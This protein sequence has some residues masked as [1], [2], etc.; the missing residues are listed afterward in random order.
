MNGGVEVNDIILG[1]QQRLSNAGKVLHGKLDVG[2]RISEGLVLLMVEGW[3]A[4]LIAPVLICKLPRPMP[5]ES[6]T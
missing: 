2:T 6:M 3:G 5:E 1:D 4:E